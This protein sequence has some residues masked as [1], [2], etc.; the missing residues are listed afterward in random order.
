MDAILKLSSTQRVTELSFVHILAETFLSP[1]DE[2]EVGSKKR[3]KQSLIINSIQNMIP[4]SANEKP[5]EKTFTAIL[6]Q[7]VYF[8]LK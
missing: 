8:T 1:V 2:D 4:G 3:F 7:K 5:K 6:R